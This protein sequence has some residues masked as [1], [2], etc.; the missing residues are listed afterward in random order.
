MGFTITAVE[1]EHNY[2]SWNVTCQDSDTT[3]SFAHGF[4]MAPDF[5]NIVSALSQGTTDTSTWGMAVDAT[6]I[7]LTKQNA[8]GSGGTNVAKVWAWRPHSAAR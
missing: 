1:A 8:T 6:N 2:K 7:T 3:T 5:Y 4:G